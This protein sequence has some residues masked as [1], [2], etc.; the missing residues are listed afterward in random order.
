VVLAARA[1]A[2][3]PRQQGLGPRTRVERVPLRTASLP[4]GLGW[5]LLK[6]ME[7]RACVTA[8]ARRLR[9]SVVVAHSLMALAPAVAAAASV[10]APV[11][12][13]A[14]E[15]ETEKNGVTGLR[16]RFDRR[17]EATYIRRVAAVVCVS[18]SIA[19]WYARRYGIPRPTVVRNVPDPSV[20]REVGVAHPLR[21]RL[22]LG[23]D[24]QIFLY[25]GGFF[26]GRRLEQF[27]RVFANERGHRHLV[28]MGYGELEP[29]LR[30]A[31]AQAPNVHVMPA[32][33]PAEVLAHTRDADVGLVGV[34]DVCLSYRYSL[35]NKLFEFLAAGLPVLAPRFPEIERV[36]ERFGCGRTVG[37][38][39]AEWQAAVTA[40]P[41]D[42]RATTAAATAAAS[43]S[44]TW[45]DEGARFVALHRAVREGTHT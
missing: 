13:D 35:P 37:E 29:E 24:A 31:A 14:H 2:G 21:E 36:V 6:G 41:R 45:A 15:L 39:D 17:L 33:P 12:Y 40:V 25:Q 10:G 8:E 38:S 18:D 19:D 27:V 16:Q 26:R 44:I 11:I 30:D 4:K 43:R 5:Q 9:P 3:L 7:Y 20:Q 28:M 32:V 34:D 22:G 23:S 42:W 1:V